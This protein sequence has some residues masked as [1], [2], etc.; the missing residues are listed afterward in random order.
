MIVRFEKC[1]LKIDEIH[2]EGVSKKNF[3]SHETEVIRLIK[4]WKSNSPHIDFKTSGSTDKSKLVQ[5]KR[6]KIEYSI[7]STMERLD[8]K[9]KF[10]SSLLC[11]NPQMIGGAM[12]VFR[13]LMRGLDLKVIE[14]SASP[15]SK[16]NN[17]ESYDLVSL[18]PLQMQSVKAEQ[19][20]KF[21]AILVGGADYQSTDINTSA[22]IYATF[23]MTETVSHFALRESNQDYYECI[24]DIKI[25]ER[26]DK[27]LSIKG[28]LTNHKSLVTSDLINFISDNKFDWTGRMDFIINSGAVKINPELVEGKLRPLIAT[29][30][31]V[32]SL[33]DEKLG[34]KVV[35]IIEGNATKKNMNL[36]VLEKYERPK[37]VHFLQKFSRTP[38][39]K[40]DR[41]DTKLK[42]QMQLDLG[43]DLGKL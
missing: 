39:A 2:K 36:S 6:E 23:G 12:V 20:D 28:T 8:P 35:L 18:V 33:D 3:S 7:Q 38:S 22:K 40:I 24:G 15:L 26:P 27:R 37:E 29:D 41:T 1:E 9:N 16:L 21:K 14:P 10:T 11:I 34:S 43:I 42:L 5:I 32:T 4:F 19:L 17:D 13:A 30:F 31:M 25:E